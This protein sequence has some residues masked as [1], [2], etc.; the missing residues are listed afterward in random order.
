MIDL[1]VFS[2]TSRLWLL[3]PL[4]ICIS[5]VYAGT[6]HEQLGLIIR[7][8]VRTFIWITGFMLLAFGILYFIQHL[9]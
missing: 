8:A 2:S 7:R 6:H 9:V 3:L 5:F 4:I 1:V